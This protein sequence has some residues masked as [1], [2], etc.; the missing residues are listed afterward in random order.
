MLR[1]RVR[2]RPRLFVGAFASGFGCGRTTIVVRKVLPFR[3]SASKL[4]IV[5]QGFACELEG[6]PNGYTVLRRSGMR[7]ALGALP[8]Y[9][10]FGPNS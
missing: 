8:G 3:G 9:I 6:L 2:S 4:G 7:S 1:V 5:A 10:C